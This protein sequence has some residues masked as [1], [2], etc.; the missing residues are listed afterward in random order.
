MLDSV[1]A[2][3]RAEDMPHET[4]APP[5]WAEVQESL[6]A[7]SGLAIMLAAERQPPLVVSNNNSICHTFQSSPAHAPLCEPYCGQAFRRAAE[8][9]GKTFYRCHAG[10]HCFAETVNLGGKPL[11]I[12]GGRAFLRTTDYRAL[13][14]R[15]RTGDLSGLLSPELFRNVIFASSQDLSELAERIEEAS[16]GFRKT[17]PTRGPEEPADEKEAPIEILPSET[18]ETARGRETNFRLDTTLAEACEKALGALSQTYGITSATLMF[19]A[20]EKFTPLH[21]IGVFEGRTSGL[22]QTMKEIKCLQVDVKGDSIPVMIGDDKSQAS[23][24]TAELFP[25]IVE[26]DVKGAL[27]VLDPGTDERKRRQIAHFAREIALPLEVLRL[28]DELERRTRAAVHLRAFA[29]GINAADPEE[30]YTTILRHSAEL[31]H[32]ERISLML[33]DESSNELSVKAAFG[34]HAEC[35]RE[36]RMRLGDGISGAVMRAGQPVVVHNLQA[37][38]FAP[39]PAERNYKTE[40]FIS[41]PININGRKVGV[42]NVTDKAGGGSYDEFDLSLL[43]M[44]APQMALALDRTEWHHKATQFQLLSITDPLTGL[45]NRRYLEERLAEEL[46]RSKRHHFP[47][48]FMMVDVDDFKLYNDRYGHQA[49]DLALEITAQCMRAVLR[50]A[51]VASRYGGEEFSVLLPQTNL[52]EAH[53]IAERI[54]GRVERMKYPNI[55]SQPLGP[56]T[57]SI[58]ISAFSPSHDTSASIIHAADQA[59]YAAKHRGKNCVDSFPPDSSHAPLHDADRGPK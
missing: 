9:G 21:S 1:A 16:A 28:R 3:K 36:S 57:V 52:S 4:K 34:P 58:G 39:A 12:I 49:G 54:R 38:G 25:L 40:S 7:A 59:L 2:V 17:L 13:G 23:A 43:E 53:V 27:L 35:A 37:A 20:G 6:A 56:V 11:G 33:F 42:L 15:F 45:L 46:E 32:A 8:A 18:I 14:E 10:L 31:L 5:G 50:S 19:R 41:Y 44:I 24:Q 30:T 51:D 48:C 29:E 22:S 26:D 55:K 47:M